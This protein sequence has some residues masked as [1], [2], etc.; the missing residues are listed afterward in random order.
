M[1]PSPE[2]A[3]PKRVSG[4]D[5]LTAANH[6]RQRMQA[7]DWKKSWCAAMFSSLTTGVVW[8]LTTVAGAPALISNTL[9]CKQAQDDTCPTCS[10]CDGS[11]VWG[12][13]LHDISDCN[14]QLGTPHRGMPRAKNCAVCWED[15]EEGEGDKSAANARPCPVCG[16]DAHE[17]CSGTDACL[18][19]EAVT[20]GSMG[21]LPKV[22]GST[23]PAPDAMGPAVVTEWMAH[24]PQQMNSLFPR[25]L[26]PA[27]PTA[28]PAT[29]HASLLA[30][31][32][33]TL[34]GQGPANPKPGAKA[35][36]IKLGPF[37][38]RSDLTGLEV[39]PL[40]SAA[41]RL[42]AHFMLCNCELQGFAADSRPTVREGENVVHPH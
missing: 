7:R 19:C 40:S 37:T 25:A 41:V 33:Q 42:P 18:R 32:S 28:P 20:D 14:L 23:D 1:P 17:K 26:A 2:I 21:H 31:I 16:C 11:P 5:A 38:A 22:K 30:Q 35:V 24:A 9:V 3:T 34:I 15:F 13:H 10:R 4:L 12:D 29:D 36:P 8:F 39:T 27:S 6:K